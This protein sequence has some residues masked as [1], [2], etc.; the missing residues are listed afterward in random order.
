MG[1]A[2]SIGA[3]VLIAVIFYQGSRISSYK[4]QYRGA[5]QSYNAVQLEVVALETALNSATV[6]IAELEDGFCVRLAGS[7]PLILMP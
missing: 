7:L 4:S 6:K 5:E 1:V 3:I 2:Q